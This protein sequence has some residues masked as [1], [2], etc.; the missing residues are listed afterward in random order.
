M[1]VQCS[2]SLEGSIGKMFGLR[3]P[4]GLSNLATSDP[5]FA[6]RGVSDRFSRR[7]SGTNV[8]LLQKI[9]EKG[10]RSE[11]RI[12]VEVL[13]AREQALTGPRLS[14]IKI[15]RFAC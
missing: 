1:S 15:R 2:C 12:T 10:G 6:F 11:K 13:C 7:G 8:V 3:Y 5:S 4:Y 9:R 14:S